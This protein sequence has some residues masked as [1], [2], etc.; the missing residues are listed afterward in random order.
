MVCALNLIL[1]LQIKLD[2]Q[3]A[4]IFNAKDDDPVRELGMV[5]VLLK[6][7]ANPNLELEVRY[8]LSDYQ[9]KFSTSRRWFSSNLLLRKHCFSHILNGRSG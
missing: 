4:D 5:L 1:C 7:G 6:G 9:D 2:R 3:L 8:I